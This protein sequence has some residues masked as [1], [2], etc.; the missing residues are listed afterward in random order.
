MCIFLIY[1]LKLYRSSCPK[2]P[3]PTRY[4][5]TL[6]VDDGQY[7]PLHSGLRIRIRIQSGQLIWIWIQEC[8]KWP[9]KVGKNL[10]IS[11]FEVLDVLFRKLKASYVT[12]MSFM[13]AKGKVHCISW[14]K[15]KKFSAVNFS[16]F[17]HKNPW[18][19]S[20]FS[21]KCWIRI[22]NT[23][24]RIRNPAYILGGTWAEK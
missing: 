6:T 16:I 20:V 5:T 21:L 18:S 19:G 14:S 12:W 2:G 24:I 17:G 9:T 22:R 10:E 23:W 7:D 1:K 4:V 8:K 11:C 3:D 15:K 13:E